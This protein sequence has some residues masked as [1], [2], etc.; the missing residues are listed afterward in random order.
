[1]YMVVWLSND[2]SLTHFNFSRSLFLSVLVREFFIQPPMFH[3]SAILCYADQDPRCEHGRDS[4]TVHQYFSFIYLNTCPQK[5]EMIVERQEYTASDTNENS[6]TGVV[7]P[8][9]LDPGEESGAPGCGMNINIHVNS[10]YSRERLL[11]PRLTSFAGPTHMHSLPSV[12][13]QNHRAKPLAIGFVCTICVKNNIRCTYIGSGSCNHHTPNKD[14]SSRRMD[15]HGR[16]QMASSLEDTS[17]PSRRHEPRPMMRGALRLPPPPF[18]R[19][20]KEGANNVFFTIEAYGLV[21]YRLHKDNLGDICAGFFEDAD[22]N[23]QAPSFAREGKPLLI[24]STFSLNT[25]KHGKLCD[26]RQESGKL[27][28]IGTDPNFSSRIHR[29]KK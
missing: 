26:I 18:F 28:S 5:R 1:M 8:N 24:Y 23:F 3:T 12:Q 9:S 22:F 29:L 16:C 4:A 13:I 14:R 25:A 2:Q 7:R 10:M 11:W 15:L 17:R 19:H 6:S 21:E 27:V 20:F